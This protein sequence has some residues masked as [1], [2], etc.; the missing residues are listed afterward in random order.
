MQDLDLKGMT[1]A[2]LRRVNTQLE[3]DRLTEN[4]ALRTEY[5]ATQAEYRDRIIAANNDYELKRGELMDSNRLQLD[6]LD[7]D[8]KKQGVLIGSL[9]DR[10]RFCE[11]PEEVDE[12]RQQIDEAMDKRHELRSQRRAISEN[13]FHALHELKENFRQGSN[14]RNQEHETTL[15]HYR[16]ARIQIAQKY[17]VLHDMVRKEIALRKAEEREQEAIPAEL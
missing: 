12:L 15:Q 11:T 7:D 6:A 2:E 4:E 1:L 3:T 5:L 9:M 16:N 8:Y 10:C 14:K 13:F 17:A